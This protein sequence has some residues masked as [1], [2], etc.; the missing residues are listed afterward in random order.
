MHVGSYLTKFMKFTFNEYDNDEYD[1]D[2]F[3]DDDAVDGGQ[4]RGSPLFE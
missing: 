2:E 1:G 4:G 3:D